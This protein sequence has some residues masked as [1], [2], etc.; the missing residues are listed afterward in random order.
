MKY[1]KYFESVSNEDEIVEYLND[2]LLDIKDSDEWVYQVL[3]VSDDEY[4][5]KLGYDSVY[6]D[7]KCDCYK[8]VIESTIEYNHEEIG[9]KADDI[10]INTISEC[11]SYM[12]DYEFEITTKRED[13]EYEQLVQDVKEL[14]FLP[15]SSRIL[16]NYFKGDYIIIR[17][18]K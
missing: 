17:F 7:E 14:K 13:E 3:N 8:I 12:S 10:V 6:S 1:L 11:I 15:Y 18:K 2:I 4:K 9:S 16:F 5:L